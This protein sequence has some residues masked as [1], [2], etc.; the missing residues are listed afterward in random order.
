M[1]TRVVLLCEDRQLATFIRRFLKR[2]GWKAHEIREEI[3]PPGQGS[4]EQWVRHQYPDELAA[5]R[6]HGGN[7]VLIV[8]TDADVMSVSERIAT[9]DRECKIR[10]IPT[11]DQQE[12]VLMVVP[13]RNIETWFAYLRGESVDE[14]T[15][16]SRYLNEADCRDDVRALDEM[17]KK[18]KLRDPAPPSLQAA[19]IEYKKMPARDT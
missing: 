11:R 5:M 4:G 2:R 3:A 10:D 12:L 18:N 19:C 7:A 17:C 1:S 9:L 8:G 15:A 6:A 13:K 16:Y 14:K